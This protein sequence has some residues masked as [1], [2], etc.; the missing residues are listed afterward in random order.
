[1][2]VVKWSLLSCWD[3]VSTPCL[4]SVTVVERSVH[5]AIMLVGNGSASPVNVVGDRRYHVRTAAQSWADF[6]CHFVVN[7]CHC[8]TRL[9]MY[10]DL[11]LP[12]PVVQ[13]DQPKKKKDKGKGKQPV[14]G[15]AEVERRRSCWEGLSQAE[16]EG[17]ARDVALAGHRELSTTPDDMDAHEKWA[18]LSLAA[19]SRQARLHR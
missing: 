6:G 2:Y 5:S 18:T 9:N 16:R 17:V 7:P 19:P 15:P 12:F 14:N 8:R 13:P 10:F 3:F 1:M 4:E 11:F